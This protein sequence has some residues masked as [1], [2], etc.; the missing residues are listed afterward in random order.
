MVGLARHLLRFSPAVI[1]VALGLGC[2]SD[3]TDDQYAHGGAGS[4]DAGPDGPRLD[5]KLSTL[6]MTVAM[7]ASPATDSESMPESSDDAESKP[8]GTNDASDAALHDASTEADAGS[9]NLDATSMDA[10][11]SVL[12][13][14]T[15]DRG[16]G[17][18]CAGDACVPNKCPDIGV[19]TANPVVVNVGEDVHLMSSP[20]DA[21]GDPLTYQWFADQG[22]FVDSHAP[23]TTYH[24]AMS[25][26][27][28]LT[29]VVSDGKCDDVV[30]FGVLCK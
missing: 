15:S 24:C 20:T 14:A 21:N 29:Y 12:T 25:G 13:D 23:N 9:S 22:T 16:D 26:M 2:G 5:A 3:E 27:A 11:A 4:M 18:A 30:Q 7:E 17:D 10:D 19:Y 6:G 28:T 1:L 8:D